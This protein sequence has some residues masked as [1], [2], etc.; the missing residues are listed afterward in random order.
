M[1]RQEEGEC[2]LPDRIRLFPKEESL[3]PGNNITPAY[4]I[5][6]HSYCQHPGFTYITVRYGA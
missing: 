6:H 1:I 3:L 5:C 4:R 2:F